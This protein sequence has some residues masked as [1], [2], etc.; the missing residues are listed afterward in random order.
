MMIYQ[1]RLTY[2]SAQFSAWCN[3]DGAHSTK[4]IPYTDWNVE[5]TESMRSELP[6]GLAMLRHGTREY[7]DE[8]LQAV[9]DGL[10]ELEEAINGTSKSF[11]F[12]LRQYLMTC[13]IDN[14]NPDL[15]EMLLQGLSPKRRGVCHDVGL[16]KQEVDK[17]IR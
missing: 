14:L 8:M 12:L 2:Y 15:S 13:F 17:T 3:R 4:K 10:E 16:V 1:L 9:Q 7:F 11:P 5:L 6:L